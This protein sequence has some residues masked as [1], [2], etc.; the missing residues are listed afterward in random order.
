MS[1]TSHQSD[2]VWR[3]YFVVLNEESIV[4]LI[5]AFNSIENLFRC[6]RNVRLLMVA[7]AGGRSSEWMIRRPD[8]NKL[9]DEP[10]SKSS[11]D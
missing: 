2:Q 3:R 4:Q 10:N 9:L 6:H 8:P 1:N 7:L 5:D 11:L